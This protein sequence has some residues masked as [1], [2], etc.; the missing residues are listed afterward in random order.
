[1]QTRLYSLSAA[2]A[3]IAGWLGVAL[4]NAVR[5]ALLPL[6]S[7]GLPVR[8]AH[9][10]ID[11]GQTLA[12]GLLVG[13]AVALVR[14]APF[15]R[16]R[17]AASFVALA[18]VALGQLVLPGDLEGAVER[19]TED[20]GR[21]WL[22]RLACVVVS[23]SVPACFFLGRLAARGRWRALGLGAA[24]AVIVVNDRILTN[25]YPGA[26]VFMAACGAT[27]LG[28]SLAG[29]T[30]PSLSGRL[31]VRRPRPFVAA[32]TLLAATAVLAPASGRVKVEL[33]QRDTAFL[34]PW[35][36]QVAPK[37][38]AEATVEIPAELA[39]W[40]ARRFRRPDVP[41]PESARLLP[42]NPIVVLV[43][44]DAL[45]MELVE[46]KSEHAAPNL[47]EIRRNAIYFS[48]A[49]S[50]G[51]DTRFSLAT[52]FGGRHMSMMKWNFRSR[53][54]P[55][56]EN[57]QRPR[58]PE[59]LSRGGVQT[60]TGVALPN[61]L[62]PRIGIVRG[63]AEEYIKD[64]T[65][66]LAGS[67]DIVNHA[68]ERLRRHGPEPLFYFTHLIDPHAPYRKHGKKP[69]TQHEAYLAEVSLSDRELGRLRRAIHEL[70]LA[71]RTVLIVS[72]DHG[73]GFG[74]HGIYHHNKALY[75]VMVHVPLMIELPG[76]SP[77]VV[78]HHVSLM[79]LGPTI[80]Q[81]FGLPVPGPWMGE[82][83]VPLLAGDPP[84][85]HRPIFMERPTERAML[86]H[87]GIK[88]MLRDA[89]NVEEIYD[90]KRDPDELDNLRDELGSEGDRRVALVR[91][92]AK[93][94]AGSRPPRPRKERD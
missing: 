37:Q 25:G 3:A 49:R 13:G 19:W 18:A 51:S 92:Y 84:K 47:N 6:G 54:R 91:A 23:L 56:L 82:S 94:H 69:K 58:L 83:L 87:D 44:I 61:M 8:V 86:F 74:E 30:L 93:A 78:D 27:L 43:T 2:A 66:E 12:I 89:D 17:Y 7:G 5:I 11:F 80:L 79:D 71:E 62:V 42:P 76:V 38:E 36:G 21:D 29:A 28:A 85:T 57:D 32:A 64:D 52:L 14:R 63:F 90:L 75:E 68:I 10:A 4:W 24:A 45:R 9:L 1:M 70:G 16:D 15:F 77:R 88:V 72:S 33:L 73:E 46:P 67:V 53:L 60:V 41:P 39:P 22:V 26:H 35:L 31:P 59:L 81:L 20:A 50:S 40:Y 65:N 48:Q 55:T 34:V